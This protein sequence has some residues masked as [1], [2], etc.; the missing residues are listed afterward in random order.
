MFGIFALSAVALGA[1]LVGG[2]I[3]MI[4]IAVTS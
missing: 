4:I 3:A 1:H 2:G